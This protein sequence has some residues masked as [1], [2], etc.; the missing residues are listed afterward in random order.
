MLA[1][2]WRCA[3]LGL[4]HNGASLLSLGPLLEAINCYV[5]ESHVLFIR[6]DVLFFFLFLLWQNFLLDQD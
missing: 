5:V 6:A 1:D 2:I 4:F 3:D